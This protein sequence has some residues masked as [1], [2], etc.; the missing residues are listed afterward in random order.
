M[1][2]LFRTNVSGVIHT[3]WVNSDEDDDCKRIDKRLTE[4]V[5]YS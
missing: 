5:D 2:I 1:V 4:G 3:E